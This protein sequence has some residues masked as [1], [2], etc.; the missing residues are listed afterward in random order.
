MVAENMKIK[1]LIKYYLLGES[2]K[3]IELNRILDKIG[4]K[5][6]LTDREKNFLDLYQT[7]REEEMKDFMLLSKN[8][9][10]N[11]VGTLIE[12]GKRVYCDLTDKNGKFGLVI[13]EIENDH[14]LDYC[15]VTMRGGEKHKLTDNFLYNIIYNSKKDTYSLQEHDEYH[16]KIEAA[17]GED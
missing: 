5:K 17:N 9:A 15:T 12:D 11:R 6:N 10:C 1:K 14:E 7:T 13:T 8:S 2:L 3:E 16:E 4:K